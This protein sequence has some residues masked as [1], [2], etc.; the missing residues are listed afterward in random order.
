[1]SDYDQRNFNQGNRAFDY[2]PPTRG[3]SGGG[4]LIFIGGIVVLFILAMV[5]I[6]G[7]GSSPLPEDGTAPA[8]LP[9][10]A[11]PVVDPTAPVLV[12]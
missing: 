4:A 5:F 6:G 12:D 2:T 1:M 7:N 8:V 9:A 11:A 3:G 10:D